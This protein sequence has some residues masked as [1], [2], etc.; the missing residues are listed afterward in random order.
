MSFSDIALAALAVAYCNLLAYCLTVSRRL[1]RIERTTKTDP[2]T[3][4]GSGHWLESERWPAALRSGQP[5]GV[6]YIDLD[7]LKSRNDRLGHSAGD[8]YIQDAAAALRQGSRRG[9]DEVFRL[10]TAG[11]EFAILVH[12][13][14]DPHRLAQTLL[15]RLRSYG[16]SASLGVAYS[17]ETGYLPARVEL[18][19]AA[20]Q[21][22]RQAKKLGGDRA[23]VAQHPGHPSGASLAVPP[24]TWQV[25]PRAPANPGDLAKHDSVDPHRLA[26][27]AP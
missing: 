24:V 25:A 1:G 27:A 17:T 15:D 8:L 5:L 3:G 21:A 10:Y 23:V 22:C 12:G 4:L 6:V 9:V 16:V 14:L 20:E 18:R 7:H 11:D 2:H 19:Q 13:R 26:V